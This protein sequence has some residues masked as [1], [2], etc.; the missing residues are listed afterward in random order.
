MDPLV[1]GIVVFVIVT[2]ALSIAMV[3]AVREA[4]GRGLAGGDL[5]RRLLPL[6]LADGL[7][8]LAWVLWLVNAL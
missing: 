3:F 6:L 1:L 8:T 2:G 4:R 5:L 7:F